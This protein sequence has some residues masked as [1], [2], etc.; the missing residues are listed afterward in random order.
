MKNLV[1]LSLLGPLALLAFISLLSAQ[2]IGPPTGGGSPSGS[3][4]GG[5]A[6][7]YPNPTVATNANLTGDVTSVGNATTYNNVVPAAKGGAG[8]ITGALRGSGAGVVTQAACADLSNSAPSCATDATNAS[9][10]GSGTLAVT[11]GGVDQTA[12]STYTPTATCGTGTITTS[13]ITGRNK[14]LTAKT[15]I[16]Q[17]NLIIATLGT[18]TGNV[19]LSLP[20]GGAVNTTGG[21]YI[22]AAV[23]GNSLAS[24]G[25]VPVLAQTSGILLV[26]SVA[27]LANTYIITVTYETT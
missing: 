22:G 9:N 20:A 2:T 11:R 15:M 14:L 8:T 19:T 6:G 10:I 25:Y 3:A 26:F 1:H 21:N 12:W 4:G 24:T 23:D 27:P 16:V 18:C 13:T 7:T 17:I 5:L